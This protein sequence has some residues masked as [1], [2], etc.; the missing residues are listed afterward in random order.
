MDENQVKAVHSKTVAA[1]VVIFNPEAQQLERVHHLATLFECVIVADNSEPAIE[2][3]AG[4]EWVSMGGNRGIAAALNEVCRRATELGFEWTFTLDQDTDVALANLDNFLEAFNAYN[5]K[6]AT[7]IVAPRTDDRDLRSAGES[8][9]RKLAM[10]MT[11]GCLTNLDIWA[12]VGGFAEEL[13]IDE[14]DHEYCL[15]ARRHGYRVVRLLNALIPHQPGRFLEVKTGD[16]TALM[17]WHPPKRLYYI[18]RNYWYLRRKY[19]K[20]FPE[21]VAERGSQVWIK[22]KQHLRYHPN[23]L[24]SLGALLKGTIHGFFGRFGP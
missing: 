17:T 23:K 5:E 9:V 1:S 15:N 3:I 13:F 12:K 20:V 8:N 21:I 6:D 19:G 14:V 11:S 2:P 10:V 16:G 4:V 24:R 18:A 22:Y 7:A